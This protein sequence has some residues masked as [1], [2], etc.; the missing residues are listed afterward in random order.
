MYFYNES[1]AAAGTLLGVNEETLERR[2][3]TC[4]T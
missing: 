2:V 1:Y 3:K 4:V